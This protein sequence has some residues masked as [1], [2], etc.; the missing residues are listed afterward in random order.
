MLRNLFITAGLC[1]LMLLSAFPVFADDTPDFTQLAACG[2]LANAVY[3]DRDKIDAELT[4]QG[5]TLQ[6]YANVPGYAVTWFVAVN[7]STKTQVIAIRGTSN[8][9]NAFVD[10][11]LQLM[12][13]KKTGVKLH[14]GFSRSA[15]DVYEQVLPL[16]HRDYHIITIGHSLGGAIANILAMYLDVDK[17]NV[18]KVVTFGQP[19]VTNVG[20]A[21]KFA[22]LDVTRVVTPKDVVPLVPPLDPMSIMSMDIYWHMGKEILLL[23]GNEYAELEGMKS[24][25]RATKFVTTIPDE[26]N[27]LHHMMSEYLERLEAK[28]S[29]AKQV[30]YDTGF[31]LLGWL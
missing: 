2:R 19:K 16:L 14:Q 4:R 12:D 13:D 9:E 18:E 3:S 27:L 29:G 25:L 24:M 17:F 30:P 1:W 11:A 20:G 8:I 22:H 6:K 28:L 5:Y 7:D 21:R 26:N 10:V 15:G 23:D 31:N